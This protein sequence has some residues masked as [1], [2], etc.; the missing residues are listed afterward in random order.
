METWRLLR[1]GITD[2]HHHFA[3]EET[4]ARLLDEGLSP[5]TLR[6][7]QVRHAV[8]VGVT[9]DVFAEVD[10]DY[11]RAHGITIVRRMNG[12]GAVYHDVGSFCYSAFFPRARFAALSDKDL[13]HLFARPVIRTCADYGL[14]A[15]ESGRNDV[16]ING[17]KIYG[18]AQ[19]AWYSAFV[20]SGTFLVE[21]DF[22]TMA[23]ALRPS[24]LK[25]A[26]KSVK[27]I[28][29]RVTSLNRELGRAV[30]VD[31]VMERLAGHIGAE[32]GVRLVPGDLTPE[33]RAL[34]EQLWH[35]K[36][37][38]DVWTYG[39]RRAYHLQQA[40]K[41][42]LGI[43]QLA[44]EVDHGRIG[45]VALTG[46][47]LLTDGGACL[48]SAAAALRDAPLSAAAERLDAVPMPESLRTALQAM[49][50]EIASSNPHAS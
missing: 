16:V 18:S 10:V 29:D 44:L 31:E 20:Q 47:V 42:P 6:L 21:I 1:D 7:R 37:A 25:F 4:I 8:F 32:L 39:E 40:A 28:Y 45:E 48:S 24:A 46:D 36:Y 23:Q 12:G 13:F 30:P 27:T 35:D 22:E 15:Q 2:A 5:P 19:M 43:I 49:L 3:V 11:C 41:T 38:T 26:D 17:R 50:R 33:E 9:Q 14:E 34:A